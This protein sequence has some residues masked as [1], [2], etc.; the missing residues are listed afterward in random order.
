V[1]DG[2]G[3][4]EVTV[5]AKRSSDGSDQ[6]M[7]VSSG[8]TMIDRSGDGDGHAGGSV[9]YELDGG[10]HALRRGSAGLEHHAPTVPPRCVTS[11][12]F[13]WFPALR[14]RSFVAVS[15]NPCPYCRSVTPLPFAPYRQMAWLAQWAGGLV[16]RTSEWA[17]LKAVETATEKIELDPI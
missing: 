5:Q 13:A 11:S 8:S 1:D 15:V 12:C 17:E 4:M 7:T 9:R 2:A 10:P 3:D 16:S 6:T 14:F